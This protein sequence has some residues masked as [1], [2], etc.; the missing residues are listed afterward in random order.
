MRV[1]KCFASFSRILPGRRC[2]KT[3][4]STR[5]VTCAECHSDA[6]RTM[7]L[8]TLQ[9]MSG[10]GGPSPSPSP[11][12]AQMHPSP[13]QQQMSFGGMGNQNPLAYGGGHMQMPNNLSP[14]MA[15]QM[16]SQYSNPQAIQSVMRNPSP[17][18]GGSP[19]LQPR[20]GF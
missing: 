11:Q 10:S 19:Y 2:F 5:H 20:Q 8:Q 7:Q 6:N 16:G 18:P 17:G 4:P 1:T 12:P 15:M 14:L 3:L 9:K 13:Q